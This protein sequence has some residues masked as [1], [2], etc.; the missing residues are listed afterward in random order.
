MA[1]S[2]DTYG[3]DLAYIHDAGFGHFARAAAPVLLVALNRAKLNHGLVVDLGC[4]SGILSK[5]VVEAGY[6]VLGIEISEAMIALAQTRVPDG[7][8][9]TESL[10]TAQIPSC[11]AVTAV[12]EC[13]N[14]LF[15]SSHSRSKLKALFRRIHD[16]LAPGGFFLGDVA[17]P[18]RV[19]RGSV[20][21]NFS[22]GED[23]AVLVASREDRRR[24]VLVREITSFRRVGELY[25][26]E[27]EI[28]H[29]RMLPQS[30]VGGDLQQ[31]GLR[32]HVLKGYGSLRFGPGHWGFL[33]RKPD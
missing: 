19:P 22:E 4:G 17:G 7:Q 12:G 32:L 3:T 33:A 16:A 21:R 29:L 8:F 2:S 6:Q 5:F 24:R 18:G 27:H 10:L 26:R 30:E 9:R 11:V 28:H 15:D 31:A 23:W 20:Q 1:A 25:R 13:L 14:Y